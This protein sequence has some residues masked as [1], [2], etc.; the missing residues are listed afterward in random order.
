MSKVIDPKEEIKKYLVMWRYLPIANNSRIEY[1]HD[2]LINAAAQVFNDYLGVDLKQ[3]GLCW[4]QDVKGDS[5]I[6]IIC[7]ALSKIEA[8][9]SCYNNSNRTS[10]EMILEKAEKL[11]EK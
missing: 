10:K 6:N 5:L 3:L 9:L 8:E 2:T 4:A 1:S 7:D 11:N